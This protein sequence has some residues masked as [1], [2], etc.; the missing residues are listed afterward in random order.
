[1]F[2]AHDI[3]A[4]EEYVIVDI[5]KFV[6]YLHEIYYS[7]KDGLSQYGLFPYKDEDKKREICFKFLTILGGGVKVKY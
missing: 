4:L 2:Y 5:V 6:E 1:M 7:S 3:P